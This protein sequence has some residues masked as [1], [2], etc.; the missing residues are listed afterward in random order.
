LGVPRQRLSYHV[1]R[2]GDI[3]GRRERGEEIKVR[4]LSTSL[5]MTR[6]VS[7]VRIPVFGS[8]W[9]IFGFKSEI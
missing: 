8:L 3:S 7:G 4:D 1:D 6:D 9:V 5:E 2:S